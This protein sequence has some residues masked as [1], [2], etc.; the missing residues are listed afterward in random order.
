LPVHRIDNPDDCGVR[1]DFARQERKTGFLTATPVHQ[2]LLTGS[3]ANGAHPLLPGWLQIRCERL[4]NQ[5][6]LAEQAGV[7]HC[8][9][10]TA[11][12][13]SEIHVQVSKCTV[14]TMPMIVEST[15]TSL[16][17]CAIRAELP[18][19]AINVSRNPAT[20]F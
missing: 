4:D 15:G 18:E 7:F 20:T 17:P 9:H 19:T 16:Q 6:T 13:A 3:R 14:S 11:Y 5:K 10:H 1:S 12:H 8:R 2:L